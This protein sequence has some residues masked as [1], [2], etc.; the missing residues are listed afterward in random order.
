MRFRQ[1]AKRE[2]T[3]LLY[4]EAYVLFRREGSS[5][6]EV[7]RIIS[8]YGFTDIGYL[9]PEEGESEL[10]INWEWLYGKLPAGTYRITKTVL[11]QGKPDGGRPFSEYP[12]TAQFIIVD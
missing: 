11:D 12:L 7:P 8:N 10:E 1:Y 3:A 4:G 5:W 9:I 6:V 2:D